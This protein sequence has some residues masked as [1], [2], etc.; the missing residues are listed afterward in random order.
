[1]TWR[2]PAWLGAPFRLDFHAGWSRLAPR[3]LLRSD[4]TDPVGAY[5]AEGDLFS[6]G[7]AASLRFD[8]PYL[9]AK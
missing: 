8:L 9:R 3:T 2:D 5:R 1:M 7:L 6:F 4:P